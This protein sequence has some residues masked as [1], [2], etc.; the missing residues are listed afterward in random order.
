MLCRVCDRRAKLAGHSRINSTVRAQITAGGHVHLTPPSRM[1]ICWYLWLRECG[2]KSGTKCHPWI[3]CRR[4]MCEFGFSRPYWFRSKIFLWSTDKLEDVL[5][6]ARVIVVSYSALPRRWS[7]C[8]FLQVFSFL[9][10]ET[11]HNLVPYLLT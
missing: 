7:F 4:R 6:P 8:D 5:W 2:F 9:C 10:T 1:G 11:Q 3:F